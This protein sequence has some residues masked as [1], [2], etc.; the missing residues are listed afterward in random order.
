MS[1]GLL[2]QNSIFK[3]LFSLSLLFGLLSP[4][5]MV[6]YAIQGLLPLILFVFC[7]N[8]KTFRFN[9]YALFFLLIITGSFLYNTFNNAIL[10]YKTVF[11]FFSFVFLF[12]LF[13]FAPSTPIP[14]W[15]LYSGLSV[16]IISQLAFSFGIIPIVSFIDKFYPYEGETLGYSSDYL[17]GGAGNIDFITNRRYG[18]IFRNPNQ[19]VRYVT[20]LLIVFLIEAKQSNFFKKLPFFSLV[21]ISVILSGSRT[22]LILTALILFYDTYLYHKK[23]NI[24]RIGIVSVLI[25]FSL[26]LLVPLLLNFDLRIFEISKGAETSLSQKFIYFD[27]FF[28]KLTSPINF[29]IG[30]FSS[31][32]LEKLYG[33]KWLDSEWAELF[34]SFGLIGFISLFS[35]Y[36]SLYDLNDRNI[37]FFLII[38]FWSVTST[39][40]FSFKMSFLLMLLLS[41]YYADLLYTRKTVIDH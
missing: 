21:L 41:K 23:E 12:L 29:L 10:D 31:E 6:F 11:R 14:K 39:I 9:K 7:I 27:Q 34:Y 33:M 8:K 36:K 37:R 22:G 3:L 40:L 17:L 28:S 32:N 30:H 19:A 26:V 16:I 1:K 18:G 20:L 38:L 15:I 25:L 13:P 24:L 5:S 4:N 35:F 2:T